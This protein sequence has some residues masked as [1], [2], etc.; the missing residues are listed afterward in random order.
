MD[1][2]LISVLMVDDEP[3]MLAVM[4]RKLERIEGVVVVGS[5]QTSDEALESLKRERVDLI[6]V[7]IK[8]A[9]DNGLELARR[10]RDITG[11][12]EIVF[13]TSHKEYAFDS[14]DIYPLDYMVKPVSQARLERTISRV[15]ARKGEQESLGQRDVSSNIW[16]VQGLGGLEVSGRDGPVRWVSRKSAELF[17]YLLL[18]R[19]QETPRSRIIDEVFPDMPLNN[20]NQYLNTA[21]YQLRKMLQTQAPQEIVRSSREEYSLAMDAIDTD[22]IAFERYV[23][24]V[25]EWD[26]SG[27]QEAIVWESRYIGELFEGKSYLWAVGERTRLEE[28]YTAFSKQLIRQLLLCGRAKEALPIAQKLALRAELDEEACTILLGVYRG[29]N[30][31]AGMR[32]HYVLFTER[33]HLE[34]GVPASAQFEDS[35]QR[36]LSDRTVHF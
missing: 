29:L 36:L 10:I 27:I 1:R 7:D 19:G 12:I 9:D 15:A 4:R 3:A 11:E 28:R 23:S 14:F 8:I 26:E 17:A 25:N 6:F 18:H 21:A 20:A 24:S 32:K 34:L 35:Y 2:Q 30:D 33:C 31:L 22:F 5:C 16:K 13:V